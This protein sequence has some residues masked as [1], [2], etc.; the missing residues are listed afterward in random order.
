[1]SV[2]GHLACFRHWA[3]PFTR[4]IFFNSHK[5][6]GDGHSHDPVILMGNEAQRD[7]GH[8]SWVHS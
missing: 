6:P 1:M 2:C 4:I 3:M 7:E 8:L 5:D